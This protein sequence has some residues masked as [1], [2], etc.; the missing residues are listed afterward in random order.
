MSRK[1]A[2]YAKLYH[3]RCDELKRQYTGALCGLGCNPNNSESLYR[4]HDIE[5]TFD[6]LFEE[7]DLNEVRGR[8]SFI[9]DF[10]LGRTSVVIS[11]RS[12]W[13]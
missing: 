9:Q 1:S 4:E 6:T 7:E 10:S 8:G 13:L 3:S 2:E 11:C 5:V 12:G